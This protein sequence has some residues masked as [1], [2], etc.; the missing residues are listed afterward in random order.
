MWS[1]FVTL[2][3][4]P[5]FG[6]TGHFIDRIVDV[7]GILDHSAVLK[8][9]DLLG[10]ASDGEVVTVTVKLDAET[11]VRIKSAIRLHPV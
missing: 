9:F 6:I 10:H 3:S 2:I 4:I 1:L 5:D 11:H 8:H 7:H